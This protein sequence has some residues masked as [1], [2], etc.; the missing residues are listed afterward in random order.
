MLWL[1]TFAGPSPTTTL[2]IASEL[3]PCTRFICSIAT[4][5][6]PCSQDAPPKPQAEQQKQVRAGSLLRLLQADQR[7]G[8]GG[9]GRKG[10]PCRFELKGRT[11]FVWYEVSA[12]ARAKVLVSGGIATSR[13]ER[14]CAEP[15][16]RD[17]VGRQSEEDERGKRERKGGGWKE[18]KKERGRRKGR[19]GKGRNDTWSWEQKMRDDTARARER[20]RWGGSDRTRKTQRDKERQRERQRVGDRETERQRDRETERQRKTERQRD[21]KTA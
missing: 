13:G 18:R 17:S 6:L 16:V 4:R 2:R 12:S 3:K 7:S 10:E 15:R 14:V 5:T 19:E 11:A 21:I 20:E 9:R 8:G 1:S